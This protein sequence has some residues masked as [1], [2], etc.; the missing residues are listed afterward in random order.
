MICPDC[1]NYSR[2]FRCPCGYLIPPEP[3]PEDVK[4]QEYIECKYEKKV[5]K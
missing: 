4:Y 3:K 2:T 5:A 1:G